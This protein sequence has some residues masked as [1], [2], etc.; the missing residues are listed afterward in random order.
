MKKIILLMPYFGNWPEWFP[1]YLESCRWNT[2]IDWLFFTDCQ[3]PEDAPTNVKFISMS[4]SEYIQLVSQRLGINFQPKSFYKI[5]DLRPAF[6]IIHQEYLKGFDYFG[7]GDIDVIYG[8][9]RAFYTDEIL[10]H[11]TLSSHS[12]RVSGHLFLMKNNEQWINAFR[13]IPNWQQ[14][15]SKPEYV[16]LDEGNFTKLLLGYRKLPASLRKLRGILDPYKRNNLFQERFSTFLSAHAC[17][18]DGSFNYP[19]KCLW[20][21][22]KLTAESGEELMYLHFMNWKSSKYLRKQ[23]G[24]KAAWESL[25]KLIHPDIVDL[26]RGFC[27]SK[28]GFTPLKNA[29]SIV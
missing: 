16:C 29:N 9:L 15:M 6:G 8:K 25:S 20:H 7:F 12:N 13:Q 5:C 3:I 4:F 10:V 2:T 24:E 26:S 27:I 22:G 14:L 19:S 18:M 21:E 28:S 11:N 23:Y 1:F 17:W